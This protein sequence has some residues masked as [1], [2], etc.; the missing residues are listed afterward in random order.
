MKRVLVSACLLGER[1]R[2][3]GREKGVP[4]I[5]CSRA[6]SQ[7]GRVVKVCPEVEGGLPVPRPPAERQPD[8]RVADE[9]RV[10]T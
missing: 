3:D 10:P 5:R 4:S 8:G 1:V 6:G 7:K 9:R 2:Y